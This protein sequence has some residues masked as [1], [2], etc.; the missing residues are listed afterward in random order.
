MSCLYILVIDPLLG[1]SFANIFSS[2]VGCLFVSFAIQKL[3]SLIRSNLFIF[4][5]ISITVGDRSENLAAISFKEC[6]EFSSR[7]L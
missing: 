2:S 7:S 1:S 6:S 3:L 5:F 4:P